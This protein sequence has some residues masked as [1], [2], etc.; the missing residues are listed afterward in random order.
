[1]ASGIKLCEPNQ[2]SGSVC[3]GEENK[4]AAKSACTAGMQLTSDSSSNSLDSPPSETL[5]FMFE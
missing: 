2:T 3:C 1:M 5:D 4:G